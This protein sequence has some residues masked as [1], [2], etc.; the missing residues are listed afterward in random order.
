MRLLDIETRRNLDTE[1][2]FLTYTDTHS[3]FIVFVSID[4]SHVGSIMYVAGAVK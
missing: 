4:Y 2:L 3:H 1:K